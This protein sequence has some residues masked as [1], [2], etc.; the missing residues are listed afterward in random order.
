MNKKIA[1]EEKSIISKNKIFFD[2]LKQV[3]DLYFETLCERLKLNDLGKDWLFEYIYNFE[4]Q[5]VG[6]DK[7]LAERKIKEEEIFE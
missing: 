2:G 4:E 7:F 3:E 6:F 5:D 1:E